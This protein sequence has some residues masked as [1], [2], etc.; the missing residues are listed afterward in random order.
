MKIYIHNE[1]GQATAAIGSTTPLQTISAVL[2]STLHLDCVFH[3]GTDPVELASGAAGAFV[4]KADKQYTAASLVQA[5]SWTKASATEDGYRFTLRPTGA[6]LVTLL[7]NLAS[8]P[9]MAQIVW[10]ESGI[11]RKTQQLS[12]VV[13]NAVYRDDEPTLSDPGAA[14][15]LPAALVTQTALAAALAALPQGSGGGAAPQLPLY[16]LSAF[17]PDSTGLNIFVSCDGKKFT[18]LTGETPVYE[19]V[20][21]LMRDPCILFH[22]GRFIICHSAQWT[23]TTFRIIESYDLLTWTPVA[24]VDLTGYEVAGSPITTT[25]APEF[26][27]DTDGTLHVIVSLESETSGGHRTCLLTAQNAAL[28]AWSA[29]VVIA[30]VRDNMIDGTIVKLGGVY[31]LFYKDETTKYIEHATSDSLTGEWTLVG[32]EDWA[33]WGAS[34]EGPTLFKLANGKHR[35]I[36]DHYNGSGLYWADTAT[37]GDLTSF[38]ALTLVDLPYLVQHGTVL[39]APEALAALACN[40]VENGSSSNGGGGLVAPTNTAAPIIYG[41]TIGLAITSTNGTWSGSPTSYARQWQISDNGTSGWTD[42]ADATGTS[43]TPVSGDLGK[44]VRIG[45]VAISAIGSSDPVYSAASVAISATQSSE[46]LTALEAYF[47][48]DE[49][50]GTRADSTANGN[51]LSDNNVTGFAAGKIGNAAVF[52]GSN[53]LSREELANIADGP[54]TVSLWAKFDVTAQLDG[55]LNCPGIGLFNEHIAHLDLW[56]TDTVG[57]TGWYVVNWTG[58]YANVSTPVP[59]DNGWHHYVLTYDPDTPTMQLWMDGVMVSSDTSAE[60][61]YDGY[62]ELRFGYADAL[63]VGSLDEAGIWSR[64]LNDLEIAQ[65]YNN[66]AGLAYPFA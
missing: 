45:V 53:Y 9:L 60:S 58:S 51:D 12:L 39:V 22:G 63:L 54:F 6:A 44:F 64:V 62:G 26:F 29:P 2:G 27:R 55:S 28:T 5:L 31:N 21:S 47:T 20:G 10:T 14:W 43:Y 42:I 36:I 7:A 37:A 17:Q 11:E 32:A 8:A 33:G 15:P 46:L 16:V 41:H 49:E 25:W 66:G 38:G 24:T 40:I 23:G 50:S 65:L 13:G 34:F 48:L 35:I 18:S 61:F 30:P 52:D 3:D 1:T 59:M 4:A 56:Y 57:A 19:P